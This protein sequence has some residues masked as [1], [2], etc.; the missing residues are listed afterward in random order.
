MCGFVG[1]LE[2]QNR[3]AERESRDTL[4]KMTEAIAHRGPD[5]DGFWHNSS[6][7]INIGHRRLAVLTR[8]QPEA[9]QCNHQ[10]VDL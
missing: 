5:S 1:F 2:F 3:S 10:V 9:N 4:K 8:V 7:G 6:A